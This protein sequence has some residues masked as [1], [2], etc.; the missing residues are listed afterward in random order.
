MTSLVSQSQMD[1]PHLE[2]D[3]RKLYATSLWYIC[4]ARLLLHCSCWST[5][6]WSPLDCFSCS[7]LQSSDLL[8]E[9]SPAYCKSIPMQCWCRFL[10]CPGAVS[11]SARDITSD[12]IPRLRRCAEHT[13]LQGGLYSPPQSARDTPQ[14]GGIRGTCHHDHFP[15]QGSH[16]PTA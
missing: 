6:V 13:T 16:H 3:E 4:T 8:L 10:T 12:I 15:H 5:R 9:F 1:P 7:V 11:C 14:H 2:T